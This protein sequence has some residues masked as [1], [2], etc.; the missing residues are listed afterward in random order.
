MEDRPSIP[1]P[2]GR[3]SAYWSPGPGPASTTISCTLVRRI[4]FHVGAFAPAAIMFPATSRRR[5]RPRKAARTQSS[6]HRSSANSGM[7]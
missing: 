3:P 1:S 5:N 6:S 7:P 2:R 4:S